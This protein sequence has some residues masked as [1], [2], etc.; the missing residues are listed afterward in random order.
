MT[1][2]QY[3]PYFKFVDLMK[4]YHEERDKRSIVKGVS[5]N[6]KEQITG[7]FCRSDSQLL[8]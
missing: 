7:P 1:I 8:K 3:H 6:F 4:N 2:L 5:F